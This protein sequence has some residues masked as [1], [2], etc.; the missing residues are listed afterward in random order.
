M[1]L[2]INEPFSSEAIVSCSLKVVAS[3]FFGRRIEHMKSNTSEAAAGLGPQSKDKSVAGER[4][5]SKWVRI[6]SVLGLVVLGG[7]AGWMGASLK[8]KTRSATMFVAAK[9][10]PQAD[11]LA[12][13]DSFSRI[14]NAKK[15]LDGL[16]TRFRLEIDWRL[17]EERQLLQQSNGLQKASRA[18]MEGIIRD[19]ESAMKDCEGTDQQLLLAEDLL[20]AL[21]RLGN[22]DR[23]L[24]V[25]L[26]SLYSHPTHPTVAGFATQ[27]VEIGIQARRTAEVAAALTHLQSIPF[28]F[29]G[30]EKVVAAL[31]TLSRLSTTAQARVSAEAAHLRSKT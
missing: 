6:S 12:V 1:G 2:L 16:C 18:R 22:Y 9:S 29:T 17:I 13:A 20:G 14:E 3:K 8:A 26:Q 31:Q 5:Y 24:D 25:Y 28:D 15:N 30:K 23:W 7:A 27:A 19:L 21:K 10:L 4:L 11:Y